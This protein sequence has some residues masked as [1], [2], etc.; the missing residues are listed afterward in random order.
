MRRKPAPDPRDC[1]HDP[2]RYEREIERLHRK[3]LLT[4]TLYEVQ[5]DDVTLARVIQRRSKVAKILARSVARGEYILEPGQVREIE[6]GGK[7]RAVVAYRLTDAIV[8]TVV[9]TLIEEAAAPLLSDRLYSYRPGVSWLTP[10][11]DFAAYIRAHR[12]DRP[13]PS[14][15]GL[16]VLRRDIDSYTDSIPVAPH[17][18][19]WA[20][21]RNVLERSGPH[22]I[23]GSDWGLVQQT[24]R[25]DLRELGGGHAVRVRGVPTGQPISCVLFN[26]YLT[27]LDHALEAVPGG[28]Y[29]RY[30]DD[31][32]FAHPDAATARAAAATI[33]AHVERLGLRTKTEK[34]ADLYLTP[35]GRRS[36]EWQQTR[37][38]SSIPFVGTAVSATGTVA[39][40]R[41]KLRRVLR[42]LERRAIR[43]A[44]AVRRT[45][46][47]ATGRAVC[48]VV[49]RALMPAPSPFQ[50][51]STSLL[52]R[53]V[54]D[55]GQLAQIDYW[56]ARMVVKAVTGDGSTRAFRR[57]PYRTVREEWGLVSL[58]HSRNQHR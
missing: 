10:S 24:I 38:T 54:T 51:A 39:L 50:Q 36:S 53:A 46:R 27:E 33:D 14:R 25:P 23:S 22:T 44:A 6:V 15:R 5:Q 4:R 9:S 34:A 3:H 47:A 43:S 17:S 42:E 57:V 28:F 55:R 26:L 49:N 31:I 11:A 30:S 12:R 32:L 52:R 35:A 18:P 2:R 48:A 1:L 7:V 21:V 19:L 58:L 20:I 13:D 41:A 56:L 45:D 16:Y 37:G 40:S 29:A 8:T